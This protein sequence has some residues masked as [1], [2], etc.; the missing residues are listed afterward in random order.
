MQPQVLH[1]QELL[2]HYQPRTRLNLLFPQI[3]DCVENQQSRQI[4]SH[5]RNIIS[6][7][8]KRCMRGRE[9]D[10]WAY[11]GSYGSSILQHRVGRWLT[12]EAA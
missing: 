5:D 7:K 12:L 4:N 9:M 1:L 3:A 6:R 10:T 11:C 8:V 2:L